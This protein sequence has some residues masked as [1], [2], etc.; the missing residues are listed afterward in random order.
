MK[1]STYLFVLIGILAHETNAQNVNTA[2]SK[3]S[4]SLSK[5]NIGASA[6][7]ILWEFQ[8][9]APYDSNASECNGID[10][11]VLGDEIACLKFLVD[12]RY[13]EKEEVA[14]ERN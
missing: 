7:T 8:S 12:K 6:V 11:D 2:S 14:R 3:E 4:G 10:K 5:G 13:V 9:P 1:T